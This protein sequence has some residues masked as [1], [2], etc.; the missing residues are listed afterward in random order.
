[1][2]S[3][4]VIREW[5]VVLSCLVCWRKKYNYNS[6]AIKAG[7]AV[8]HIIYVLQKRIYPKKEKSSHGLMNANSKKIRLWNCANC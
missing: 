8:L 5:N 1:M 2:F 4:H 7:V 3:I 6:H